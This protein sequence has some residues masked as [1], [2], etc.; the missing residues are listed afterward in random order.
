MKAH[1]VMAATLHYLGDF[2]K[3]RDHAM[4]GVEM[5]HSGCVEPQTE[6]LDEPAIACLCHEALCAWHFGELA[7]CHGSIAEAV[8]LARDLGDVH[9]L[10]VALYFGAILSQMDRDPPQV[11]RMVS[12]LIEVSNRHGFAHFAHLGTALHGWARGMSGDIAQALPS[13][14]DAIENLEASGGRLCIPYFLGLKAEA[15]QLA[16]TDAKL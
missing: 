11:E 6:E 10:A 2:A 3:A 8:S 7:S 14:D 13:I 9:G 1:M 15:L 16:V 12:E 4:H 5:I